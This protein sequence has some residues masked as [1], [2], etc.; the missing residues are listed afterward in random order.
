MPNCHIHTNQNKTC[1]GQSKT[2]PSTL[3]EAPTKPITMPPTTAKRICFFGIV[4]LTQLL[5]ISTSPAIS[6]GTPTVYQV[7]QEYGFPVGVLPKGATKYELDR[8]TGKFTVYLNKTCTFTIQGYD[9]KYDSRITG[10]VSYRKITNLSGVHVKI[11]FFWV[12]IGEVSVDG[13]AMDFSVGIAS[14]DFPVDN[15]YESPQCGCGFDC[16]NATAETNMPPSM[17]GSI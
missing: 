5:I 11:L 8:S 4:F 9:L 17:V 15:F 2:L 16:V 10:V 12:G 1:S 14:A 7:L 6:D 13:D 3:L